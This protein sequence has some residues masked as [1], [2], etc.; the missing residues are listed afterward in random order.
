VT[1]KYKEEETE[2]PYAN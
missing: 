1:N 2:L